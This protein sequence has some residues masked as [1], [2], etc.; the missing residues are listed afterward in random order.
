MDNKLMTVFTINLNVILVILMRIIKRRMKRT[1]R[2]W[3]MHPIN[4]HRN[5][6]GFF[7]TSFQELKNHPDKF[8]DYTRMSLEV[9]NKLLIKIAPSLEKNSRRESLSPEHRLAIEVRFKY[10]LKMYF[11]NMLN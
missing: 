4:A 3:W 2:R 6:L 11:N 10:L 9:F 7:Y 5:I 8:F 1:N